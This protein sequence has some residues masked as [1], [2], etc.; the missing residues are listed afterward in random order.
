VGRRVAARRALQWLGVLMI[1]AAAH[2]AAAQ[3]RRHVPF[4]LRIEGFV[5]QKPEGIRSLA[6]WVMAVNGKQYVV[7]VTKLQPIG[8]DVAWWNIISNLEPLP[9]TL[10]LY[11]NAP[12]LR[13]FKK[14]PAG[15]RIALTGVFQ[16]GPGP[17]TL[18]LRS[19]ES[20]DR[21]PG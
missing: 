7:H 10:T 1:A 8:V 18:L 19:V 5:G 14:T 2:L 17:V 16:S 9:V 21:P 12:L 20:L 11:G 6:R 4:L 13:R 3:V 15:E